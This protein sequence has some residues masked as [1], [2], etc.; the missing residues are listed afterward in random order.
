MSCRMSWC[1]AKAAASELLVCANIWPRYWKTAA[2]MVQFRLEIKRRFQGV[3]LRV[4]L[5]LH[6]HPFT[7]A[8]CLSAP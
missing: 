7:H 2:G 5:Y 8:L 4:H 3:L 6:L 1:I